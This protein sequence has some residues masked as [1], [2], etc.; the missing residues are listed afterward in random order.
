MNLRR[1]FQARKSRDAVADVSL[2]LALATG[3]AT[4]GTFA[5][6]G[7]PGAAA[8]LFLVY[9]AFAAGIG[10]RWT[11]PVV[12]EPIP[13]TVFRPFAR[14]DA[15]SAWARPSDVER[16]LRAIDQKR[17]ALPVVVGE[18]GVGKSVLMGVLVA[19]A[20]RARG[21]ADVSAPR[22]VV[23]PAHHYGTLAA[24]LQA[25]RENADPDS[26]LI[27]VLDQFE[28]WL[29]RVTELPDEARAE[30]FRR[31]EGVLSTARTSDNH[32][33]VLSLRTEWY[34]QLRLLGASVPPPHECCHIE[35]ARIDDPD[36]LLHAL[37]TD[38]DYRMGAGIVVSFQDILDDPKDVAGVVALL[39]DSGSISP[40]EAQ[41]VGATIERDAKTEAFDLPGL[42]TAG[43][44]SAVTR[45]FEAV[46]QG[47]EHRIL[48][49]K[50]LCALSTRTQ[51]RAQIARRDLNA[52][53]FEDD[54][55]VTIAVAYLVRQQLVVDHGGRLELAHDFIAAYFNKASASELTALERDSVFVHT[56]SK[57][58]RSDVFRR[59]RRTPFRLG[60]I[61]PTVM[62]S[63]M[64]AR[65]VYDGVAPLQLGPAFTTPVVGDFVDLAYL[66]AFLA[67]SAWLLYVTLVYD[68]LLDHLQESTSARLLS[69]FIM[70]NMGIWIVV[71]L[72]SPANWLIILALG[73]TPLAVKIMLLARRTDLNPASRRQLRL[74]A[75]ITGCVATFFLV[76]GAFDWFFSSI[77]VDYRQSASTWLVANAFVAF[78]MSAM[79]LV[80][81]PIHASRRGV[82]LLKSLIARP[83]DVRRVV[84][85]PE[86]APDGREPS[87]EPSASIALDSGR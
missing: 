14:L 43:V 84:G 49:M 19:A 77:V 68:R 10:I 1:T 34:Y 66:P 65:L 8:A 71:G 81:G 30:Q 27:I 59:R 9:A 42:A 11:R 38:P 16:V 22:Y 58:V 7:D 35:R 86:M 76:I 56:E 37:P 63:V 39:G 72:A 23:F 12:K 40:L 15:E 75:A 25:M 67:E 54:D 64:S 44:E 74:Y 73:G 50:V 61:L 70:L 21:R 87:D 28:Q 48:T 85:M 69:R 47:A 51:L 26:S 83:H 36:R 31:L 53:L 3:F 13:T 62:L 2:V 82:S 29:A 80:L 5:V 6:T 41:I 4:A 17:T 78:L 57:T 52:I 24:R 60:I 20:V 33:I 55:E 45:F 18:S 46:L 32:T 79:C